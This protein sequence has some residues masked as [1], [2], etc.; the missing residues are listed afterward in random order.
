METSMTGTEDRNRA[1]VAAAEPLPLAAPCR[2]LTIGAP[3]A[4]IRLG[5]GDLIRARR[6]SLSYGLLM[7][8]LC[9]LVA[10]LTWSWGEMGLYLGI[11]SAVVFFGPCQALVLYSISRHLERGEAPCLIGSLREI[12][13]QIG[14]ALVFSLI[15]TVVFLLWGRSALV[16]HI[17]YPAGH[18]TS[19]ADYATFLGIGSV[20][21][22][23]FA[24][25]VFAVSAFSLPMMIDRDVDPVTAVV[26]SVNAVLNNKPAMLVWAGLIGGCVLLGAATGF[27]AF[28]VLLPLLGHAAWHG[29]RQSIDASRWPQARTDSYQSQG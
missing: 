18:L 5:W 12:R 11:L 3:L 4:W 28:I 8:L 22:A 1:S 23:V 6:H 13:P 24:A 15:L 10:A 19:L 25:I 29:Y 17:F 16:I 27:L 2:R 9:Y 26:T 20:V 7:V 14:N 21:G